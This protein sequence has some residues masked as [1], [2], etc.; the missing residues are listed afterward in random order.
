[1]GAQ[2]ATDNRSGRWLK[3]PGFCTAS[4]VYY[5]GTV[6]TLGMGRGSQVRGLLNYFHALHAVGKSSYT[7]HTLFVRH[8]RLAGQTGGCNHANCYKEIF[9]KGC[10]GVVRSAGEAHG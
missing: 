9:R 4:Q 10:K 2:H 5:D 3:A 6:T 1:M 7:L 8:A